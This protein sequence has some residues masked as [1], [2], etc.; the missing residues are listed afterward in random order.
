MPM[1]APIAPL[2]SPDLIVL[3]WMTWHIIAQRNKMLIAAKMRLNHFAAVTDVG[4]DV[5]GCSWS[6]I[7]SPN[8]KH[9]SVSKP[10]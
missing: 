9:E 1:P 2:V 4:L 5:A 7:V 3:L 6:D 10:G 8:D